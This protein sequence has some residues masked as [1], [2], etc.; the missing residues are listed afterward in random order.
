M[1]IK[2]IL[3]LLLA[4]NSA[5]AYNEPPPYEEMRGKRL[6]TIECLAVNSYH[7]ARGDSD[8]ANMAVNS[9]VYARSLLGGRYGGSMCEVVFKPLAYSWTGD[10]KVDTIHNKV[11]YKRLYRLA[12]EFLANKDTYL[13]MFGYAD[14]Y[15]LVGHST[16]WDYSKLNYIGT[17]DSHIFYKHK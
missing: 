16:N 17:I 9:S 12:E 10:G 1:K 11:Q 13:R 5:L 3:P 8:I 4:S 7:E 2:Y 15:H 14:H 6:S